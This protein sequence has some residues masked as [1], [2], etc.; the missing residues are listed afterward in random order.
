[1][2]TKKEIFI[3]KALKIHNNK[4]N[5]D[6]VVYINAKTKIEILCSCG[7]IFFV[8]PN[9]HLSGKGCPRCAG[10]IKKTTIEFINNSKKIH[11]NKYDYSKS[12]Y[13]NAKTKIS[14]MCPKHGLF[15]VIPYSH[16]VLGVECAKCSFNYPIS[17]NDFLEKVELLYGKLF[18]YSLVN[19]VN[20]K[21]K[22]KIKCN[23]GHIFNQLPHKHIKYGKCP[24]CSG[25]VEIA[26]DFII[27]ANKIHNQLYDYSTINYINNKTKI[28]IF[29]KFCKKIF[30]QTPSDH[31]SGCGCSFCKKSKGELY[32]FNIL[33]TN[34]IKFITEK[35]FKDCFHKK[36]LRFDFYLI[37][38]NICIEYDGIQHFKPSEIFGGDEGYKSLI[39]RDKIKNN[40]CEENNIPLIRIA[41]NEDIFFKLK[42]ELN[43][44]NIFVP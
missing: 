34:N 37:D 3:R 17:F 36:E 24:K 8:K 26:N 25:R 23:H 13:I 40:Y 43:K 4:F 20:A 30:L 15:T 1:M 33:K 10:N 44:L 42:E 22:I 21:T 12:I 18:D 7:Y 5:Y 38:Y 39:K 19:Y 2:E 11:G 31:L 29:C 14:I 28:S 27:N 35:K 41:Y 9:N 16:E 6:N 32:I